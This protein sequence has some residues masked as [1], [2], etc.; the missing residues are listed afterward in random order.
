MDQIAGVDEFYTLQLGVDKEARLMPP[1]KEKSRGRV[2]GCGEGAHQLVCNEED[3]LEG[4]VFIAH[5]EQVF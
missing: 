1:K 4:E 3:G 5:L 2:R